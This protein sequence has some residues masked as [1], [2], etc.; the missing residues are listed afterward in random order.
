MFNFCDLHAFSIEKTDDSYLVRPVLDQHNDWAVKYWNVLKYQ[1][2]PYTTK[3][4]KFIVE[5]Y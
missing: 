5:T 3:M 1:K 2:F 4:C